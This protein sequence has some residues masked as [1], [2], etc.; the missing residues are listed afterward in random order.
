M[1]LEKFNDKRFK[2][3][4]YLKHIKLFNHH[5]QIQFMILNNIAQKH[6]LDKKLN[7]NNIFDFIMKNIDLNL[8]P[9][10]FKTIDEIY[11]IWISY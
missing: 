1:Q 10:S 11:Y 5:Q 9:R 3:N 8:R 4:K 2:I 7:Y 6:Y